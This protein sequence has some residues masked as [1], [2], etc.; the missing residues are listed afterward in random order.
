[1][2][3]NIKGPKPPAGA[4]KP[5]TFNAKKSNAVI[6]SSGGG[7]N[8]SGYSEGVSA[9]GDVAQG[10]SSANESELNRYRSNEPAKGSQPVHHKATTH[11]LIRPTAPPLLARNKMPSGSNMGD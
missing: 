8:S 9:D 11:P 4:P 2:K 3:T 6:L 10:Y 5:T 1:M 7:G